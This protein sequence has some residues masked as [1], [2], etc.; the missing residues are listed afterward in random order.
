MLIKISRDTYIESKTIVA[1]QKDI[2]LIG[3]GDNKR[4]IEDVIIY[5][6]GG[7]KFYYDGTIEECIERL[8]EADNDKQSSN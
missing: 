3:Y 4:K 5:T 1:I 2:N 6:Q 8:K 7:G